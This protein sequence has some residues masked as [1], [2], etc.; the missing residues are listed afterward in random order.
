VKAAIDG[1]VD[2]RV[3][4]DDSG[5]Y[6]ASLSH[7]PPLRALGSTDELELTLRVGV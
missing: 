1:L 4:P 7:L 3:L 5:A 6:V 2:A